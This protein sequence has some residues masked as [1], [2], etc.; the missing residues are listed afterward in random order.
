MQ[1]QLR[2]MNKRFL[3]VIPAL[4]LLSTAGFSGA[5]DTLPETIVSRIEALGKYDIS[6]RINPFYLRGDFDADGHADYAVLVQE[7]GAKKRGIAVFLSSYPKPQVLGAGNAVAYGAAKWDD[8]NFDSWR[9]YG[10]EKTDAGIGFDPPPGKDELM[11]VQKRERASGF[12]RWSGK[13]F[14][15]IQQG[16]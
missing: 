8:L 16:D 4:V 5:F 6:D 13:Q 15:W 3:V 11:L 14:T 7:R 9:V 1:N 10:R 12:F 2:Q